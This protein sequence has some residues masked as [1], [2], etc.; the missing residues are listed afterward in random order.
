MHNWKK[1]KHR[2]SLQFLLPVCSYRVSSLF[3]SIELSKLNLDRL[4]TH[5]C[6]ERAASR[7]TVGTVCP[8]ARSVHPGQLR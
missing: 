6:C 7:K 2:S 5:L 8:A 3:I 1:S 4:P